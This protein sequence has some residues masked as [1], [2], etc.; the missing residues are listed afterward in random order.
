MHYTPRVAVTCSKRLEF[1]GANSLKTRG[2]SFS[3]MMVVMGILAVLAY[4]LILGIKNVVPSVQETT[5]DNNLNQLNAAVL[6][7][8]QSNWELAL[9][10]AD[11]SGDDETAIFQTLQYRHPTHPSPGSPYLSGTSTLVITSDESTYRAIWNGRMFEIRPSGVA[12]TGVDLARMAEQSP[13]ISFAS[14]YSPV[15]AN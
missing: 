3:E 8:N 13:E 10:A 1:F 5:A 9:P 4:V 12:G 11:G 6:K 7:F 14:G 2:M 15:G